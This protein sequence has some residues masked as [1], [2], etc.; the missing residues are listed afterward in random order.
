MSLTLHS[1]KI[2][3]IFKESFD[4]LRKK[5]FWVFWND[6]TFGY[7]QLSHGLV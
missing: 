6:F 7:L 4:I 5:M 3:N 2:V 1:Y